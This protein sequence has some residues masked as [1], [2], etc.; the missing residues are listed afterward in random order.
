MTTVKEQINA[1]EH[2]LI[3]AIKAS[4][5]KFLEKH[6]HNDLL[7][8]APNGQTITKEIDL[9]SH[10]SKQMKVESIAAFF[11]DIKVVGDTVIVLV[12]YQTS[13]VMLGN[14]INGRFKYIRFWK[15]CREDFKII[16]GSCYQVSHK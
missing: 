16:G 8:I 4:D 10:R 7:F 12:A 3:D 1:L 11:E 2:Q 14:P 6:L 9:M 13:G 15:K 5:I